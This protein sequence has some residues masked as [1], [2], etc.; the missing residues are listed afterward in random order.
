MQSHVCFFCCCCC[1][2]LFHS[3]EK[4]NVQR[5]NHLP[6]KREKYMYAKVRSVMVGRERKRK[7]AQT[8]PRY[9]PASSIFH[10]NCNK[11]DFPFSMR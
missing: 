9:L 6:P 3:S 1:F 8:A 2:V 5:M 4:K 10:W 11:T 7:R